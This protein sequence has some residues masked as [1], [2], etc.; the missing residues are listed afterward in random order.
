TETAFGARRHVRVG[1]KSVARFQDIGKRAVETEGFDLGAVIGV[2]DVPSGAA[3]EI[4]NAFA[5][6][7]AES[8]KINRQ[9][10][11]RAI[12]ACR[13]PR[14]AARSS[15]TGS[16]EERARVR[17]GKEACVVPGCP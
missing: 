4:E 11:R 5:V 1:G 7:E 8:L 6:L 9:H 2:V 3:T 13:C 15:P 14:R 10:A 17:A 16:A 12:G